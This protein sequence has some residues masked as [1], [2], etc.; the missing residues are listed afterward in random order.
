MALASFKPVT[1]GRRFRVDLVREEITRSKDEKSLLKIL[2]KN[3]GRSQGQITT[4]H[5]GGR[6]KRY[7]RPIDF[8]RDKRNIEAKVIAIEYDPN[9]NVSVALIGFVDG[10]KRY[11]LSPLNLKVGDAVMAA[12]KAPVRQGNALPL[13]S[14]PVGSLVH[15]VEM[16]PGRGGQIVRSAGSSAQIIAKEAAF[17]H[18]KLPS[19]EV[20]KFDQNAWATVGQLGNVDAKNV[21][22][23]KAGRSR[24]MGTRPTVRGVAQ[25]PHSHPHGGG[26]GKSGIGMSSPKSPWGKPTMGNKTR[27][28]KKSSNRY[29]VSPRTKR[30]RR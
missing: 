10:E 24:L 18:L 20:R 26:E 4:R 5:K 28:R 15:N 19:G 16:V 1:K 2:K 14:L 13:R 23:G 11:I 25:D 7:Y 8:K 12:E 30:R 9:R 17:V 22:L 21:K 6:Q 3:S 27:K 29:I